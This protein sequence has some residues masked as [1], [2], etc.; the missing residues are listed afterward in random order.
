[1]STDKYKMHLG[2]VSNTTLRILSVKGGGY[3]TNP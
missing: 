1:M 2:R 3:P